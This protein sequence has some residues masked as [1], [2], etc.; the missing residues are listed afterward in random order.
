MPYTK[1]THLIDANAWGYEC[2]QGTVLRSGRMQTQA[3]FGVIRRM[4]DVR[5][6]WPQG[7][8]LV[9]WDGRAQW[10]YDLYPAYKGNRESSPERVAM[11]ESYA[12]Q[13]PYIQRALSALGVRQI[14][15]FTHEADDLA[16][17]FTC[18]LSADPEHY[19]TLFT[20][21]QDWLQ[22]IRPNVC[23]RDLR[24]S[25][26]Y[27]HHGN[28]YDYTGCKT[29]LEFLERKCLM[30]DSSDTITGVGGLGEKKAQEFIA[31][32]G[33]VRKFWAACDSGE[34][35]PKLKAEL[36]L[37][38]GVC[39]YSRDQWGAK[40][41][42]TGRTDPRDFDKH[43]KSWPGQG[44][45]IFKR[46][47]QLMQ[48]L[49]VDPPKPENINVIERRFDPAAFREVCEELSFGSI[50]RSFDDFIEPFQPRT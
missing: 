22:M 14:T 45:A 34:H 19:I 13:K 37:W 36:S 12:E 26:R 24:D 28:F 44:R 40:F 11:R 23:W 50:L 25:T 41:V 9:L 43:M 27:V 7:T 16:G 4:R 32:W 48:L 35:A 8:P 47:F 46:N 42:E 6:R 21:D 33:S 29:P 49:K 38:K 2:Q 1:H 39:E 5:T 17:H 15:A 10:R 3:V 18:K 20:G 31:T 30:G